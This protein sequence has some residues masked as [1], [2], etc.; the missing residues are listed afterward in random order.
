MLMASG[1]AAPCL[2]APCGWDGR[3][4]RASAPRVSGVG[5]IRCAGGAEPWPHTNTRTDRL[6]P[7]PQPH[8]TPHHH[9]VAGA[10]LTVGLMMGST[11]VRADDNEVIFSAQIAQSGRR[12]DYSGIT[13]THLEWYADSGGTTTE[14]VYDD[15][16]IYTM[17]P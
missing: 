1:A 8:T 10:L 15:L 12:S 6:T 2:C 7:S 9:T 14:T 4:P 3:L 11:I 17:E 13:L 5:H 16:T